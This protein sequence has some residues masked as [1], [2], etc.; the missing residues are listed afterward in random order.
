MPIILYLRN[1]IKKKEEQEQ[2]TRK[3][4]K[5]AKT[6]DEVRA[7]GDTLQSILDE[8]KEARDMLSEEEEKKDG[9]Q[10]EEREA[11]PE[12]AEQ[13]GFNPLA[14]FNMGNN[15][16]GRK[17]E[18]ESGFASMEYRLAFKDF[19]Q[20]GTKIPNE[21]MARAGGD[22]GTTVADDIG[23]II[24]QTIMNEFIKEV[25]KVYGQIYSKVRK[26]NVRGGVKFPISK[27]KATFKWITETTVS[28]KQKAGEINEFVEFNYNIG[29]IRVAET[30]LAQIVSLE[31]FETEIT[32][33][34][35]EAD[36]KSVV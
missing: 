22:T 12:Q 30:L 11:V 34:M 36:R 14:S 17:R 24:P 26:L 23:A 8:L 1:L 29:E 6:A 32:R 15:V 3:K 27:L 35:V 10:E 18:N 19:V 9:E 20:R 33:I 25:S 4:M 31:L 16:P 5:D 7:L 13:R 21:V 28:G 2:E